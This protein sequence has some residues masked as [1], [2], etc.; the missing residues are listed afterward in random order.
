MQGR[1]DQGGLES[2]SHKA[3]CTARLG[4][5]QLSCTCSSQLTPIYR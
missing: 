4:F 3:L 5:V 1:G 2:R